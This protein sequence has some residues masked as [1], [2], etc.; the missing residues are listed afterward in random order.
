MVIKINK[1]PVQVKKDEKKPVD[2]LYLTVSGLGTFII[3]WVM[4]SLGRI[5][6]GTSPFPFTHI[7][8]WVLSCF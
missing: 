1:K 8:D 3:L 5:M 7:I 4:D 2:K 6:L